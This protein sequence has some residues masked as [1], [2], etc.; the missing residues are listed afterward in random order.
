M[1]DPEIAV[2]LDEL[3]SAVREQRHN[4]ASVAAFAWARAIARQ[5]N[6]PAEAVVD[7]GVGG[8]HLALY[9]VVSVEWLHWSA[10]TPLGPPSLHLFRSWTNHR[11]DIDARSAGLVGAHPEQAR[12]MYQVDQG[13]DAQMVPERFVAD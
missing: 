4:D 7:G 11:G 10:D 2:A 9:R 6:R 8:N 1:E 12:P 13:V 3:A 5:L